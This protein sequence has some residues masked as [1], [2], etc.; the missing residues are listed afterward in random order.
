ML[1]EK[2]DGLAGGLVVGLVGAVTVITHGDEHAVR[3]AG[4][5]ASLQLPGEDVQ[6]QAGVV[7]RGV[8]LLA[9]GVELLG[10][11]GGDVEPVGSSN[12][13]PGYPHVVD[14]A[15]TGGMPPSLAKTL[16][17]ICCPFAFVAAVHK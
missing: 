13:V 12:D 5:L 9:G 15:D 14:L 6:V 7:A 1:P 2:F 10:P 3:H 11:G 17:K 8:G 16:P 4:G